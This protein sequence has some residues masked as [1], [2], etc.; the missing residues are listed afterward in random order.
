MVDGGEWLGTVRDIGE[1]ERKRGRGKRNVF[2][3]FFIIQ[4]RREPAAILVSPHVEK[5]SPTNTSR[6][7]ETISRD[8]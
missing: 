5:V 2:L 6:F 4:C 7:K 3:F 1:E 8:V